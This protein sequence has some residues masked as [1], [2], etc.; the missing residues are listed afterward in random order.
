MVDN[1][2]TNTDKRTL[3]YLDTRELPCERIME[4]NAAVNTG[5]NIVMA[6]NLIETYKSF[7]I[8][9]YIKAPLGDYQQSE[10]II[11]SDLK[12]YNIK[13]DGVLAWKDREVELAARL[14][15]KLDLPTSSETAA[16]KVRNKASTRTVLDNI[17]YANPNYA[18][19]NSEESFVENLHRI[20]IPSLIKPAGNSGGRGIFKVTSLEEGLATYHKFISH[21]SSHSGDMYTYYSNIALLEEELIGSEH[22]VAGC[23]V[24]KQ[25]IIFAIIDKKIDKKVPIQYQNVTPSSL[26]RTQQVDIIQ[27]VQA[28]V[29]EIGIDWCG[30]HVDIMVTANGPKVL[31]IGGR[32]GGELINSHLIPLSQP[33]LKPY[34]AII[35]V[36]QGH[37]PFDKTDYTQDVVRKAGARIILPPRVGQ[38][39]QINGIEKIWRHPHTRFFMQVHG[40]GNNMELPIDKFKAYEIGYIVAECSVDEDI[41]MILDE[42]ASLVSIEI[43]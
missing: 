25:V 29:G 26:S 16:K 30:F 18:I 6:S 1:F 14:C 39:R 32:L 20:G 15:T 37:N 2:K 19:I 36:I 40:V 24:D 28:T 35:D 17:K 33:W 43:I 10:E 31:E 3:L 38:I 8:M 21:N 9:H 23:V 13:I 5:Y 41:N 42:I 12:D 4:I 7:N 34:Q 11:L 22:S 27:L